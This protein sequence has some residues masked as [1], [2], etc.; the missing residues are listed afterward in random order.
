MAPS[1]DGAFAAAPDLGFGL[2][3]FAGFV[4]VSGLFFFAGLSSWAAN[5]MAGLTSE[6]PDVASAMAT[7]N[8]P[9]NRS[10][11]CIPDLHGW[12]KNMCC[13]RPADMSLVL[14]R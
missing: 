10:A 7:A 9:R 6:R 12:G 5:V 11:D 4:E 13:S 1:L 2:F 8:E 14:Q 3:G